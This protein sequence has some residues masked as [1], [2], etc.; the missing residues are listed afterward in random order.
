MA[1]GRARLPP[2]PGT[3]GA[4]SA[5]SCT[6]PTLTEL[7]TNNNLYH[8]S[9]TTMGAGE[10]GVGSSVAAA[11]AAVEY[12]HPMHHSSH[13]A[14]Q[15]LAGVAGTVVVG[16]GHHPHQHHQHHHQQEA[17]MT[18]G[19]TTSQM[20][21]DVALLGHGVTQ[22]LRKPFDAPRHI[23]ERPSQLADESD[24]MSDYA[25]SNLKRR[26][27]ISKDYLPAG[28][29]TSATTDWLRK[30][31]RR[32]WTI[33]NAEDDN[34]ATRDPDVQPYPNPHLPRKQSQSSYPSLV[35]HPYFNPLSMADEDEY[36]EEEEAM[37]AAEE[38]MGGNHRPSAALR[39]AMPPRQSTLPNPDGG[40]IYYGSNNN[41]MPPG[42]ASVSPKQQL[43]PSP[44]YGTSPYHT[45]NEADNE[46]GSDHRSPLAA[47]YKI[48][49]QSTLPCKPNE[50]QLEGGS[51]GGG[52]LHGSGPKIM[53]SSSPNSRTNLY[54]KS[55][56]R[57]G[58]DTIM[59]KQQQQRFPP[60]PL[61]SQQQQ[62]QQQ[63]G[64]PPVGQQRQLPTSPNRLVFNKSP[65]SGTES[66]P[67]AS[68]SAGT[69]PHQVGPGGRGGARPGSYQMTRQATLPNPEQHMKLLPTSPPKKQLSP[70]SIKRSPDFARQNTLPAGAMAPAQ[71]QQQQPAAPGG[72]QSAPVL[73]PM[74]LAAASSCSS[75]VGTDG[76]GTGGAPAGV[77]MNSLS[78]H[79]HG[80]KFM[81]ISPRQ[82]ASFLFPQPAAPAPRPFH[83]Q[84]HFPTHL[85]TS[86]S[87]STVSSGVVGGA[88]IGGGGPIAGV[89]HSSS[90]SLASAVASKMIKVRSHSN[91][92]YTMA[93]AARAPPALLGMG[94]V[95]EGR[96]MLPE[97]PTGGGGPGGSRSPRLV[98]QEH[99][100][101]E[102]LIGGAGH[103]VAGHGPHTADKRTTT[104]SSSSSSPKQKTFA[105]AKQTMAAAEDGTMM[106]G[107][108][109]YGGGPAAAAAAS[110]GYD[111][112]YDEDQEFSLGPIETVSYQDGEEAARGGNEAFM[113]MQNQQQQQQQQRLPF[114]PNDSSPD[115]VGGTPGVS[116]GMANRKDRLRSRRKS[117]DVYDHQDE[118]GGGGTSAMIDG[119][120]SAIGGG[121]AVAAHVSEPTKR[122]PETMRSISEEA[123]AAK[124]PKPIT[125][126]SLSHPEKDTQVYNS[127]KL[128]SSK[129]PSPKPLT[130]LQDRQHKPSSAIGSSTSPRRKNIKS[131][132]CG[133]ITSKASN[134]QPGSY[135]AQQYQTPDTGAGS[136]GPS[137]VSPGIV[138]ESSCSSNNTRTSGYG[139]SATTLAGNVPGGGGG[140]AG[141]GG[142]AIGGFQSFGQRK[143]SAF[144]QILQRQRLQKRDSKSLDI[145]ASK[146]MEEKY[147]S[148]GQ[149]VDV[150][151][152]LDDGIFSESAG[153]QSD[154]NSSDEHIN[155]TYKPPSSKDNKTTLGEA[156]IQNAVE[157]AAVIFKK[158]VL[159]RRE[160][161]KCKPSNANHECHSS[162][163]GL[164]D[165][166]G[167][168]GGY[169]SS[170]T[171]AAG[172]MQS[173][174]GQQSVR[175]GAAAMLPPDYEE[176]RLVFFSS[177]SSSKEEEYDSS[178]TSSSTAMRHARR[179]RYSAAASAPSLDECDWDYFEPDM[180][181]GADEAKS[182]FFY[183][184]LAMATGLGKCEGL[185]HGQCANAATGSTAKA[186]GARKPDTQPPTSAPSSQPFCHC[187]CCNRRQMQYVPIPVPVPVPVPIAAFQSW[188]YEQQQQLLLM[189]GA[190]G[191]TADTLAGGASAEFAIRTDLMQ[192]LWQKFAESEAASVR[193]S[194]VAPEP[195]PSTVGRKQQQQQLPN[196]PKCACRVGGGS[197]RRELLEAT[198][199]TSESHDSSDNERNAAT[200]VRTC[201][202]LTARHSKSGS[203]SGGGGG[204]ESERVFGTGRSPVSTVGA[205]S[206]S[207]AS[208]AGSVSVGVGG[209]VH[210][211]KAAPSSPTGAVGS[212]SDSARRCSSLRSSDRD[213][214]SSSSVVDE[215]DAAAAAAA[216]QLLHRGGVVVPP[217]RAGEF[218]VTAAVPVT[219][220]AA[221]DIIAI[222]A[223][224]NSGGRS[225]RPETREIAPDSNVRA[226]GA[227]TSSSAP[228]SAG[229]TTTIAAAGA[230]GLDT[231]EQ[232]LAI[233][234]PDGLP[235]IA[236]QQREPPTA[237]QQSVEASA[238]QQ[239]GAA[240]D[241]ANGDDNR[242][243][244]DNRPG[245][246]IDKRTVND[247]DDTPP[248]ANETVVKAREAAMATT[249]RGAEEASERK[250]VKQCDRSEWL[251][252]G[253][254]NST[255]VMV[256]EG[257][258]D[259]HLQYELLYHLAQTGGRSS[260]S[261]SSASSSEAENTTTAAL[262]QQQ[263]GEEG[264]GGIRKVRVGK[265]S[266]HL[267]D[268]SN[269][270]SPY[271][272]SA[273]SA[274]SSLRER[275]SS[276]SAS[277][278][279]EDGGER[280][281]D[282]D[283]DDDDDDGCCFDGDDDEEEERRLPRGA[284]GSSSRG[285]RFSAVMVINP[286]RGS[287]GSSGS[288]DDDDGEGPT[289]TDSDNNND[290]Q[291]IK[292]EANRRR[293][294][295][296][297]GFPPAGGYDDDGSGG[298]G[299]IVVL[300]RVKNISP[301][302]AEEQTD[303]KLVRQSAE[304]S[305]EEQNESIVGSGRRSA[306]PTTEAA[307]AAKA[308]V[309]HGQQQQGSSNVEQRQCD[310][311]V[312][313]GSRISGNTDSSSSPPANI[314][315][316]ANAGETYAHNE[317]PQQQ[318]QQK[319]E[320]K[321]A[322]DTLALDADCCQ[323]K[324]PP[325]QQQ[326]QG[327]S[328]KVEEKPQH[329]AHHQTG[330]SSSCTD[331]NSISSVTGVYRVRTPTPA[332]GCANACVSDAT[333]ER[334]CVGG[335]ATTSSTGCSVAA[336]G[337]IR[338]P[339]TTPQS[340]SNGNSSNK[341]TSLVMITAAGPSSRVASDHRESV[342]DG[343]ETNEETAEIQVNVAS[344]STP[345]TVLVLPE[346]GP[347]ERASEE[348]VVHVLSPSVAVVPDE[349]TQQQQ[350]L[351]KHTTASVTETTCPSLPECLP[352]QR[353][354]GSSGSGTMQQHHHVHTT[355][356]VQQPSSS[357]AA[358]ADAA[359]HDRKSSTEGYEQN[360]ATT[361]IAA[362][363]APLELDHRPVMDEG[364]RS[365]DSVDRGSDCDESYPR[366][367]VPV[368]R[369]GENDDAAAD[370]V[371]SD[372]GE[373]F[374][375]F[376]SM[377]EAAAAQLYSSEMERY[378]AD[379]D[380]GDDMQNGNVTQGENVTV[381]TGSATLS[382]VICLEDGLADDDSWVE[383]ISQDEEEFATTTATD[384]DLD[385]SSE[386]MSF[387]NDR[388]EELRGYNRTAIDFTLHTIVEESCEDSEME[389][390]GS[391]GTH[392]RKRGRGRARGAGGGEHGFDA[393]G[394]G[395]DDE[396]DDDD[397]GDNRRD[398]ANRLSASE[399]EKY[400]FYGLSGDVGGGGGGS[401]SKH[402]GAVDGADGA[403]GTGY[404]MMLHD[405]QSEMSEESSSLCSDGHDSLGSGTAS[406]SASAARLSG[407]SFE[408]HDP[409][410]DE[411]G[412]HSADSVADLAS[413]RLEKYFLTGFLG[414]NSTSDRG[415]GGGASGGG[416]G[417][418]GGGNG[419]DG[420]GGSVGSDSEG[421]ASPEQRRKRLVRARGATRSHSSLDNL[422]LAGKESEQQQHGHESIGSNVSQSGGGSSYDATGMI[423][424]SGGGGGPSS[425]N[426]VIGGSGDLDN[427][428]ETDTCDESASALY[429]HQERTESA[430][431]HDTIGKRKK[432]F[433]AKKM[434]AALA[435]AEQQQQQQHHALVGDAG[436]G[437]IGSESE[438]SRKTPLPSIP[439]D[440]GGSLVAP[441]S[442]SLLPVAGIENSRKQTSRDSGFIGSNDDLLKEDQAGSA[443][444]AIA[445]ATVEPILEE[446]K[447]DIKE[448]GSEMLSA[449]AQ[450]APESS[451]TARPPISPGSAGGLP[452]GGL[453]NLVRKDSFNNWSSDEE[454]NLMMSKMRQ[455][456]KSLVAASA[457]TRKLPNSTGSTP[458][459]SGSNTPQQGGSTPVARPRAA[460]MRTKP[461]QLVYFESE[462]TRL[463][464]TV[465]GIRD[466]QVREIVEYLSSED[467]WSDSYDSSDYT[468]SDLEGTAAAAAVV[469]GN[470]FGLQE[471]ISASCRQIISKFD[472]SSARKDEEGD[473]GDGGL[474]TV[475]QKEESPLIAHHR[476]HH[477]QQQQQQ[478]QPPYHQTPLSKETA[479][480]YQR[481]VA[482]LSK[483]VVSEPPARVDTSDEP[484]DTGANGSPATGTAG[485]A[486][487]SSSS[488]P[489]IAKVMH[490]IGSRLVALMHEVSSGESHASVSPKQHRISSHRKS[491]QTMLPG[492]GIGAAGASASATGAM[493]HHHHH[494]HHHH[495]HHHQHISATTTE[496][497][498]DSSTSES[499]ERQHH[500][501]HHRARG[502]AVGAI[503]PGPTTLTGGPEEEDEM[504]AGEG[505]AAGMSS[506]SSASYAMMLPRSKSHD[507]LLSDQRTQGQYQY[508]YSGTGSDMVGE[509]RGEAS[510]Y[511][512]FSWR[513]SFESAL[514]ANGDSRTKLSMLDNSSS[515]KSILVAKRRSAGD[516]LFNNQNLSQEQLDRVR[517]CGSIGGDREELWEAKQQQSHHYNQQYLQVQQQQQPHQQHHHQHYPPSSSTSGS[518]RRLSSV[519]ADEEDTDSDEG[520]MKGGSS[521]RL[522]LASRST[523]P[524][525]LQNTTMTSGTTN[526]LP[527]LPTSNLQTI[528]QSVASSSA[529]SSAPGTPGSSLVVSGASSKPLSATTGSSSGGGV[530][531]GQKSQSVYHFLQN[532][533]KSAR[534]RAP[535]FNRPPS[536]PKRAMSAPG[537]QP[538]YPR[539]ERR[540]RMQQ[541]SN[542]ESHSPE[543][544]GSTGALGTEDDPHGSGGSRSAAGDGYDRQGDGTASNGMQH[545][546][547]S[548]VSSP[549]GSAGG[550]S[551]NWPS[552]SDEDIDRL[553]ALHQNR[554]SLSSLGVRSD[555]MASVYSGAGEGRY[556]TVTVRGQIEFGM[557]YNYKQG[558]LEI[559]VKQC[560]DLAAVDTKRNRSDPYVKVY[561][562]PDKSKS[563]KR[564]TKV[565]K[566]TL[567]PVF[568][569]VL[570]F[571]MSLNS[572]QTRTI[573]ITVWHSDMFGRNDFL[574]EVMMG[575]QDKVFDNPQPQW[576]Q[577][578]ERS[579]PF[580]DLSAYKGDIIVGLKYVSAD[581]DGGGIMGAGSGVIG[582]SGGSTS[583][584]FGTLNLRKFSTRSLT[585]NSSSTLS[586]HSKG[587]LHVL[588]KE[589]KHL[590]PI[591]SNG[592]CDAFCKSYLLPDKN[593]SSKQKTPVIKRTNSPVWNYTFV[594]EDVSLAEL[595][596]RALE[597]TIWDHDR[598]ASNEF[599]GGVRFSLGNGKHNGRAVEWMDSTGKELSLWQNMI[600]RPNFWVEGALVLRPSLENAKF[601][602]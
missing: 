258:P 245:A 336:L 179:H 440:A 112:F 450:R 220:S 573:W 489:L 366:Q 331:G 452:K 507:L 544:T 53:M 349:V 521:N 131:F 252:K 22:S 34:G 86:P 525:S 512:R 543:L 256:G 592:T 389:G 143:I 144:Q 293:Y 361:L 104:S 533:V 459:V 241:M 81:P 117:R 268:G 477:L 55:P 277:S 572:L 44:Q 219:A 583:S 312:E 229:G 230:A 487:S 127:K 267:A 302:R 282:D 345:T 352:A 353:P 240:R 571:H 157:A 80:P 72:P 262:E 506:S 514:L 237:P 266:F 569:E 379:D 323:Q 406:G 380:D 378:E 455:F 402:G 443:S 169:S 232:Q 403:G 483:V 121:P 206:A 177:D 202:H 182:A 591:K 556:G 271:A 401:S 555:S 102:L 407:A 580:E 578:Q 391:A 476:H 588:V 205:V 504:G 146:L 68:E 109:L 399:L 408:S 551:D 499:N 13:V 346:S 351:L 560:K 367:C 40:A 536:A 176:Y 347:A 4:V 291:S 357:S 225:R 181:P 480:V 396:D 327:D 115:S 149:D 82:K 428:S 400:F 3:V 137:S 350:L 191:A 426:A 154:D 98:R 562:L 553:V 420:S 1:S 385:D 275:G 365:D 278:D 75:L 264:G 581:A 49:R 197:A 397:D 497:D 566:H 596:E 135:G 289:D 502:A 341:F 469:G 298:S 492:G 91:E 249:S 199:A 503:A 417:N 311:E 64:P 222:Q 496:D 454:T 7:H 542:E 120:D 46:T 383:E 467:T 134:L 448:G 335:G 522:V 203:G 52:P 528:M 446:G 133:T 201:K 110:S 101:D 360:P 539:R 456:F 332:Q 554:A 124:P 471:E 589:A 54:S 320:E 314:E 333:T 306:P 415:N 484:I 321:G 9:S 167:T 247:G 364:A 15:H 263:D 308:L 593:R 132:D 214:L 168:L 568:D 118:L 414:Y 235:D 138:T 187:E 2:T 192:Q 435:R 579:E 125:R 534:Y 315:R 541:L 381:T 288:S 416:V 183:E 122:K 212:V 18:A 76:T 520:V 508:P 24:W 342:N 59:S 468:S 204:A 405:E 586:G 529:G 113:L 88:A 244:S 447:A 93:P 374:V 21:P 463:M 340:S 283:D 184:M 280:R 166:S 66:G 395:G 318:Q 310:D 248:A 313:G 535:G 10:G 119:V 425:G 12:Q 107:Y 126:R 413:S 97:I 100:R 464:K 295:E 488:P 20:L 153:H 141:T 472:G 231:M 62:Q 5:A 538:P 251:G 371:G 517:S 304:V 14:Q 585:S 69:S 150:S 159:Q 223:Q 470:P 128:D 74:A 11:A 317:P 92:E 563:G 48:R 524:R 260:P 532:N 218:P 50:M 516:L 162:A 35:K 319:L 343:S 602:T 482:S 174:G 259:G 228:S 481:L 236:L 19:A 419:S 70:H 594:Y 171:E 270:N 164:T 485:A 37:A 478:H 449:E 33:S 445:T 210:V 96:R 226:S 276:S 375:S 108:E 61:Q 444:K 77:T 147:G 390:R 438:D 493:G 328:I 23:P 329:H 284:G 274:A 195:E 38:H 156:E 297:A 216:L 189:H 546:G 348:E 250:E 359:E 31:I 518:R 412:D 500:Y 198:C 103:S 239:F 175:A 152:S 221:N 473:I 465:P 272:T 564:K 213:S 462:L 8:A 25:D 439:L 362:A 527:R 172:R 165:E 105:E 255:M 344:S 79:Q 384:S 451:V 85:N 56:E 559:H 584:G 94:T 26:S 474:V 261:S 163:D 466:E 207:N 200:K 411:Q 421:H 598:L 558:A 83:S 498:E 495:H 510:D 185:S 595:S 432:K 511:E 453:V 161:N 509:E 145:V 78:V 29:T 305:I 186:S 57:D 373:N 139:G 285:K 296:V 368:Q 394:R 254:K 540:N 429:A 387:A 526:S 129:I 51:G 95:S 386:E 423:A 116:Y 457:N 273:S 233:V 178:S 90:T 369:E 71:Q 392:G 358:G 286:G 460:S 45:D 326:Q 530:G 238:A 422:L 404:G 303:D 513:G 106:M 194:S 73:L 188:L 299:G 151:K 575:L 337:D 287:S 190:G 355:A 479:F 32:S 547:G 339:L 148:R 494:L 354:A 334:E 43:S 363:G 242:V 173:I 577:L 519:A 490:H 491:G 234:S 136:G 567:N 398:P 515:S 41:L 58:L 84:Q 505:G 27:S 430:S 142:G 501:H 16:A 531:M 99:V 290:N 17:G 265:Y 434:D 158:V 114:V 301:D 601:S 370:G 211:Q 427:S 549:V 89:S 28:A 140:L 67:G 458:G 599:L 356:A 570:R 36:G 433:M 30:S 410:D 523:L 39:R 269:S 436:P 424:G 372:G 281:E 309:D 209:R 215:A 160:E 557:Q 180:M 418:G 316:S 590:Q 123:P 224:D 382:A 574:G 196:Y 322:P 437:A 597:L 550:A 87:A 324:H 243:A 307:N 431:L 537:L 441:G 257:Q 65:D 130:E 246:G 565:K 227:A 47:R 587:A 300:K 388:E 170:E 377:E 486:N 409:E 292:A 60:F 600:N 475:A 548:I 279:S 325:E 545:K 461:P 576:Y 442:P 376:D 155:L 42:A 294:G 217:V 582:G 208:T 330:E 561:L 6:R 111:E 552:Q 193:S 63:Q 338:S 253:S 393:G